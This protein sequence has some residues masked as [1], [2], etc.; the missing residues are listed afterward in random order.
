[1]SVLNNMTIGC[2]GGG[3]MGSA[4]LSGLAKNINKDNIICFDK[5]NSRLESIKSGLGIKISNSAVD[6]TASSDVIILAVKPDVVR[7]V[8]LEIKNNISK[9]FVISVAAGISI[10]TINEIIESPKN[11]VRVMPNT[12]ALIGEG[13]S[14]ISP[15]KDTDNK[16]L[17]I[18]E[19]IFSYLGKVL[20]LPEK[21]MDAV[22]AVSGSGPAYGFTLIQAMVDGGVKIGLPRDKATILAA[23]TILGAAKMVLDS[24]DDPITLRGKV[25]SPGGTTIEAVHILERAG[26][27]GIVMDAIEAAKCKSEK[28]GN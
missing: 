18:S 20:I 25:T 4:I 2:I 12:P 24:K 3:N 23:Q 16:L 8:L 19:E 21:L 27:S 5:D 14:V 22:T 1:M 11:I 9:K 13:M 7:P 17:A 6:L 10:N 15:G 28:L 26:F